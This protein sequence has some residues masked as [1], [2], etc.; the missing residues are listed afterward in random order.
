MQLDQQ[1][2]NVTEK[3]RIS[4]IFC[5]LAAVLHGSEM[6]AND[7]WDSCYSHAGTLKSK[8]LPQEWNINLLL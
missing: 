8:P 2:N 1:L 5:H 6:D 4:S 3:S 7:N